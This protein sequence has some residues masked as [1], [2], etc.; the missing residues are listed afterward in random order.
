MQGQWG[1]FALQAQHT[2]RVRRKD[3]NT[4]WVIPARRVNFPHLTV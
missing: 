3:A 2:V 4:R 1:E